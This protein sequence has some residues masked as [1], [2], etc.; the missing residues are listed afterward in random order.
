V[1]RLEN[2]A[3]QE[4]SILLGLREDLITFPAPR[5]EGLRRFRELVQVVWSDEVVAVLELEEASRQEIVVVLEIWA[6]LQDSQLGSC[7]LSPFR[8]LRY[9]MVASGQRGGALGYCDAHCQQ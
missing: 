1:L 9:F 6:T 3:R 7:F 4:V 5:R 8:K 2:V